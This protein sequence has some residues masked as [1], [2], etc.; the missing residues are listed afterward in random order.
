MK[1]SCH[2]L[3]HWADSAP[4]VREQ[5]ARSRR[6]TALN[7]SAVPCIENTMHGNAKLRDSDELHCYVDDTLY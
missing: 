1:K 3:G 6:D 2:A 5:G 7:P 4:R